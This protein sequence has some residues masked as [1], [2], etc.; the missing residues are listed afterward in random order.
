MT[1]SRGAGKAAKAKEFAEKARQDN[2]LNSLNYAFVLRQL[3]GAK[4]SVAD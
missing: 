2:T 4:T 3:H 1:T